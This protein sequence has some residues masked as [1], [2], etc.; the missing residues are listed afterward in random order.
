MITWLWHDRVSR[1]AAAQMALDLAVAELAAR[2]DV[3]CIRLYQWQHATLS[4]G[5]HEAA[6]RTWH[7]DRLEADGIAVVRRP[8]GGRG[9][10]HAASDLTYAWG[11]RVPTRAAARERY[12]EI[13]L[14]LARALAAQGLPSRVAAPP[15]QRADL[16]PGSCFELAIGGEVLLGDRKVIGSAQRLQG[17]TALQ[18]G[19]IARD[20]H[21][22]Q[23]ARYRLVPP[24][25]R[26]SQSIEWPS[27][28]LIA[29]AIM[30][31]ARREGAEPAPA[32]LIEA[33]ETT[34][35]ERVAQFSDPA[36][37]WRR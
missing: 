10:W 28:A 34:A 32:T 14:L 8:T 5:A 23:E 37:T 21:H 15:T 19:A 7:R 2:H 33:M 35:R 13:H 17:T 25:A 29:D 16:R 1:P 26:S 4:L 12:S 6:L 30:A 31:E 24:P 11:G 18:H 3:E 22:S 20:D 27:A 36:W 9:V